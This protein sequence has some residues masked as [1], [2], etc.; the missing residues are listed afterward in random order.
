VLYRALYAAGVRAIPQYAVEKYVLDF[1][2]ID[3][4]RRLNIEVDGEQYHRAWNGELL[5]RDR[6]RNQR[7]MELGW[8]V[9][10]YWVYQVRDELERCVQEIKAWVEGGK[11][12]RDR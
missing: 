2:V 5:R 4:E 10:R 7:L 11:F 8:E 9:R 12:P 6:L 3:G 1:A